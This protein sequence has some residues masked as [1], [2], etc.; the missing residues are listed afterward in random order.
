VGA[1][2]IAVIKWVSAVRNHDV[3]PASDEVLRLVGAAALFGLGLSTVIF[4]FAVGYR[5]IFGV[6][7]PQPRLAEIGR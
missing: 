6:P 3:P 1:L 5:L 4:I 7:Q 2:G